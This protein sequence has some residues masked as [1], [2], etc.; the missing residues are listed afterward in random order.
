M[1]QKLYGSFK[2]TVPCAK[3]L[4]YCQVWFRL[5]YLFQQFNRVDLGQSSD[6]ST[7]IS[8]HKTSLWEHSLY[9]KWEGNLARKIIQGAAK[10]RLTR[11]KL[12]RQLW[13]SENL[14][15][16]SSPCVIILPGCSRIPSL[17][18]HFGPTIFQESRAVC[19][20]STAGFVILIPLPRDYLQVSITMEHR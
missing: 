9:K 14:C 10:M 2:A 18:C 19:S 12:C 4:W 11:G 1:E 17:N 8:W 3:G 16:L 15:Y 20:V 13:G 5:F 7:A 6:S